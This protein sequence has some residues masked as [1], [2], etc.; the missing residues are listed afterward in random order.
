MTATVRPSPFTAGE[1]AAWCRVCKEGSG[2]GL[3]KQEAEAWANGHNLVQHPEVTSSPVGTVH[4]SALARDV[5]R[6]HDLW[7]QHPREFPYTERWDVTRAL[8]MSALGTEDAEEAITLALQL[9]AG[10]PVDAHVSP[11]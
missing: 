3:P 1:F 2:F 9:A 8:W 4:L 11:L 6:V 5:A 10:P 7:V